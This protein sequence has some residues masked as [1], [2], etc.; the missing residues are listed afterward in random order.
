MQNSVIHWFSHIYLVCTLVFL[1]K[2]C[3]MK[4]KH[5]QKYRSHVHRSHTHSYQS[6]IPTTKTNDKEKK[7][8][9][10]HAYYILFIFRYTQLYNFIWHCAGSHSWSDDE[11]RENKPLISHFYLLLLL[12]WR[13]FQQDHNTRM[14]IVDYKILVWL[15]WLKDKG[16]R[17]YSWKT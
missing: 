6:Y 16:F 8:T 7:N 11:C 17:G 15:D 1:S 2:S 12:F 5:K 10:S 9:R 3:M 14:P 4:E 13:V